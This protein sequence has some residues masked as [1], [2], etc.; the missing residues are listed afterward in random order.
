MVRPAALLARW[1]LPAVRCSQQ[2]VAEALVA[3]P[4]KGPS[5]AVEV[6]ATAAKEHLAAICTTAKEQLVAEERMINY[7]WRRALRSHRPVLLT[8]RRRQS[9]CG[10]GWSAA[11]AVELWSATSRAGRRPVRSPHLSSRR[12]SASLRHCESCCEMSASASSGSSEG[13][14]PDS[15]GSNQ[16]ISWA[17]TALWWLEPMHIVGMHSTLVARTNAYRGHAQHVCAH[18]TPCVCTCSTMHAP[19]LAGEGGRRPMSARANSSRRHFSSTAR[20][21]RFWWR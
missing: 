10:A 5:T 13:S 15:D 6:E 19:S 9:R 2:A 18:E 4:K 8:S 7:R 11:A 14:G 1:T 17:C 16:C 3:P 12:R 20:K 21:R